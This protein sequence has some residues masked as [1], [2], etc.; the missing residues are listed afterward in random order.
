MQHHRKLG[1]QRINLLLLKRWA[2]NPLNPTLLLMSVKVAGTKEDDETLRWILYCLHN[3]LPRERFVNDVVHVWILHS[4]TPD[5]HWACEGFQGF[6]AQRELFSLSWI[7]FNTLCC[8]LCSLI[9]KYNM[10][11]VSWVCNVRI[12]LKP[13][14]LTETARKYIYRVV[15]LQVPVHRLHFPCEFQDRKIQMFRNCEGAAYQWELGC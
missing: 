1:R 13:G 2:R 9:N 3:V 12:K 7:T 15:L 10:C 5:T 4:A 6:P 14:L 11:L 8:W